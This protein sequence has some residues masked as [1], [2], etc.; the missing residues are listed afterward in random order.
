MVFDI[1]VELDLEFEGMDL[2]ELN[3]N[4]GDY[5]FV[6]IDDN[7]NIEIIE[8]TWL[9]VKESKGKISVNKAEL[10]HFSRYAFTR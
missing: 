9:H 2:E 8:R 5:D 7:G 1:P 3:L 6:F 10:N 4:E